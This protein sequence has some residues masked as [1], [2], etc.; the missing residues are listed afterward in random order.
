MPTPPPPL[1][2]LCSSL[3]LIPLSSSAVAT[4]SLTWLCEEDVLT[5]HSAIVLP[6]I[7]RK[8]GLPPAVE[9]KHRRV[10]SDANLSLRSSF[11]FVLLFLCLSHSLYLSLCPSEEKKMLTHKKLSRSSD[12]G[13]QFSHI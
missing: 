6:V 9:V 7:F 3:L 8:S 2:P 13:E 4:E 5:E 10:M 1:L 12:S 11:H